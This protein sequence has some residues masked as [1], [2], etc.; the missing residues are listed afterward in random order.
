MAGLFNA[1]DFTENELV[2]HYF[3]GVQAVKPAHI[4]IALCTT[5]CTD[6]TIGTEVTGGGYARAQLDPSENNWYSTQGTTGSPSTGNTGNTNNAIVITFPSPTLNWGLLI[7]G[8]ILDAASGGNYRFWFNITPNFQVNAG[9]QQ[10]SFQ[11]GQ[12]TFTFD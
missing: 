11:V 9:D 1:T 7:S 8:A 12:L 6:S 3:R 2:D 4:Y 5:L 10:P